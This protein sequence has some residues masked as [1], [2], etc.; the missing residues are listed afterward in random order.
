MQSGLEF[1]ETEQPTF[2]EAMKRLEAIVRR[3][4]AGEAGLEE[5]LR[6]FEEGVAVCRFLSGKLDEAEAKIEML[7]QTSDGQL[8][9][10]P[11]DPSAEAASG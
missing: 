2:E 1:G 7:L 10:V 11:F 5:S 9:R 8:R 3:L 6:L 4:E